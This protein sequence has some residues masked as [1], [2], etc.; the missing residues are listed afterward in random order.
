[1]TTIAS[2]KAVF[3]AD[4]S[5]FKAKANAVKAHLKELQAAQKQQ[6][7]LQ[8]EIDRQ[9][10]ARLKSQQQQMASFAAV[11]KQKQAEMARNMAPLSTAL[12]KFTGK[13][14]LAQAAFVGTVAVAGKQIYELG[15]QGA[16]IEY[17]AIKFDRLA[18]AADS[19]GDVFL[20]D[21]RRA[22]RGTISDFSAMQLGANVLQ[23]GLAKNTK[24][25][26]RL[27]TV[28]TAL[29]MDVGEV[30]LAIANQSTRRL[31]QLGLSLI[32]FNENKKKVLAEGGNLT[33]EQVFTEA[34]L[35]T[36]ETT[37]ATTGNMADTRL[38][39]FQRYEASVENIKNEGKLLISEA[40]APTMQG[41]AQFMS[42][43]SD[44][45]QGRRVWDFNQQNGMWT[46]ELPTWATTESVQDRMNQMGFTQSGFGAGSNEAKRAAQ[47]QL[48]NEARN[49]WYQ[50]R[51]A[52]TG[53]AEAEAQSVIITK[54]AVSAS[55]A[56][57]EVKQKMTD[58]QDELNAK[59]AEEQARLYQLQSQYGE[60]SAKVR[61]QA[62]VV[63][64]AQAQIS[65]GQIQM[66]EDF[67][68]TTNDMMMQM[69]ATAAGEEEA[70]KKQ[71]DF[72]F[73]TGQVTEEAY[74]Q[75][76]A[77]QG[78]ADAF[79]SGEMGAEEAAAKVLNLIDQLHMLDGMEVDAFV[80]LIVNGT[81]PAT[82]SG[83]GQMIGGGTGSAGAPKPS[84]QMEAS[85]GAFS[86]WAITGDSHAGLTPYS[87]MVYAPHGAYVYNASQ[88]RS[89]LANGMGG[90]DRY[91]AGGAIMLDGALPVATT[92]PSDL[93]I[94]TSPTTSGGGGSPA[95]VVA[96]VIAPA[97]GALAN[98]TMQQ[99]SQMASTMTA[100][101]IRTQE[102]NR[103]LSVIAERVATAPDIGRAVNSDRSKYS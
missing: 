65:Q 29:G 40:L 78:I 68:N 43:I 97:I 41:V 21:L 34:F 57:T 100:L 17:T 51:A 92:R 28:M 13:F 79:A 1:M 47:T 72:A 35:R 18:R 63:K 44:L 98:I 8:K 91:A 9:D 94:F 67:Q 77:M 71:L 25:A 14:S 89:M 74:A 42:G 37:V 70:A 88:T 26:S 27:A 10:A 48:V 50:T 83:G 69:I 52:Q 73:A 76:L 53:A 39:N 87:E 49:R 103:L 12:D 66:A 59:L 33:K 95:A 23:L 11:Q 96:E 32:R 60:N 99:Q 45:V 61:E 36:A 46:R 7:L 101:D 24:E 102:T 55:L 75:Q 81:L 58:V 19:T 93:G 85:G 3:T 5:N 84:I 62:E 56:L 38:G 64:Q 15:K 80:N 16:Q 30:T 31:D 2:L 54:D 86:G 22:T 90:V 4:D 82:G 6:A 20:N